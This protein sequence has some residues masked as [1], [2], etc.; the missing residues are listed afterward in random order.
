MD[1]RAPAVVALVVAH[2]PGPWFEET[3][4]ALAAQDYGEFSVLVLDDGT[5]DVTARVGAVLPEAFVRRLPENRG[6]GAAVNEALDM[7]EGAA[8]F[9]LCHDDCAP[10]PDAVHLMVEES[11]RSNA[12]VIT[13]KMVRWDDPR[14][15]VHV[16][17][18]VDKTGAVVERMQPGEVD[19]GQHDAVR[20][21]FVAPGGCTLVR[22]DLLAELGGF[23]DAV[24]AMGEDL[25][26]CWRA[27]VAGSRVVVCPD[28]VVRHLQ[29]LAAGHRAPP[30]EAGEAAPELQRLQRRHE[31]RVVLKCY[32]R[33]HLIRVVPQAL[34]L[35]LGEVLVALLVGERARARAVAGAWRDNLAGRKQLRPLRRQVQAARRVPDRRIRRRQIRGSARL[36]VY[37]S[38]LAN[39]GYDVAHGLT[40]DHPEAE[41]PVLT[42]S[43]GLAFSEDADFD[44]LDDLGRRS[45]RDRHGRRLRRPALSTHRA[46][47]VAYLATAALLAVG[48]RGL[49]VGAFP[50]VGQF[51][52][53]P[54]WSG[55]WHQL[56][57]AWQSPGL[58]TT[59]P[60]TPAF[61]LLG[62]AGTLLFGAM[63]LLDKVVVLGC[64]P[65]GAWGVARFLRPMASPRARLA[66][67]LTYLALPL[68]YNGLAL[69][70]RDGLVAYALTPFLALLLAKAAD[71]AP[72]SAGGSSAV[73][74][75]LALGLVEA[76][77]VSFAPA[78]APVTVLLALGLALGGL[79]SGARSGALRVVVVSL[80]GTAVAALLCG[81]W[82]LGTLLA[83]GS[84]ALGIFGLPSGAWAAPG[85]G[86]LLRFAVGPVAASPVVLLLPAA[87]LLPLVIGRR[88]HLAWAARLWVAALAAW[89]LAEA[90]ARGWMGGFTP[91]VTVVL[92][93]AALAVAA[94]AGL[95]VASFE[96][97]LAGHRF[98]WRQVLSGLC[99][100][101][102]LVGAVPVVLATGDG[103]F[104]LPSTGYDTALGFVARAA[105]PGST[106]VLWVG[107]P[108]VLPSGG[109]SVAPGLAYATSVDGPPA[110]VDTWSPAGPGPSAALGRA[111]AL[112]LAGGTAHLG[113]L[114]A[115]AGVG[116]VVVV[117]SLGPGGNGL[118]RPPPPGLVPALL[119]QNDLNVQ[120]VPGQ[121]GALIFVND[122]ALAVR[123]ERAAGPVTPRAGP[124]PGQDLQGWQGVLPAHPGSPEGA[125]PLGPGTLY[126][127][128]APAGRFRLSTGMGAATAT[129]IP[130]FGWAGQ[131]P[132]VR[133]GPATLSFDAPPTGV[134]SGL[135]SLVAWLA[136]LLALAVLPLRRRRRAA[137]A[138][139][140]EGPAEPAPAPAEPAP[141]GTGG[142]ER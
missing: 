111:V 41:V 14:T 52:P 79:L 142:E 28:A 75:V 106:R 90:A 24:A 133:P 63:G 125:G 39:Q 88:D 19:H 115:P 18:G 43:V 48:V 21:V 32:S 81:P 65:L 134:L 64:L 56:F 104:G 3:L 105:G 124:A 38:R 25:D 126:N 95:G 37:F 36:S 123:A 119:D 76:V 98:G 137:A 86:Q 135:Y 92:A 29:P 45:G 91:S 94:G 68:A 84:R 71:L 130:A 54:G 42:G 40:P 1:A 109:W 2:D 116:Y 10:R 67:A 53:L 73:A 97:D 114:L 89:L 69:G 31:L 26:L 141:V 44:D 83:G 12:G 4:V 93:P 27:Q 22:A 121:T 78:L 117:S 51:A 30:P 17:Q 5:E 129:P 87:G 50:L 47:L 140:A 61:G 74:R 7:V 34:L 132:G 55:A 15:L 139:A 60:A 113:R 118:T 127:G 8:F 128:Q 77:G 108:A 66:G 85:W 49:L 72:F 112:A 122:D 138:L 59:A 9:L 110:A 6:F 103:R 96:T 62:A 120:V 20:D 23:D 102:L 16:G 11:F 136:A 131:F 82:V 80:A 101:G 35:N 107:D 33:T 58:G 57:S 70:R 99:V 100:G 13:P 46:R